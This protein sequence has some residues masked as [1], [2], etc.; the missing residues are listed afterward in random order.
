M[1]YDLLFE[2]LKTGFCLILPYI[3]C[4][5]CV[6]LSNCIIFSYDDKIKR[7]ELI[8]E[9]KD[10]LLRF[11]KGKIIKRKLFKLNF[12]KFL[13]DVVNYISDVI[14][15]K[16][17]FFGDIIAFILFMSVVIGT[18][19]C[20]GAP[21][22]FFCEKNELGQFNEYKTFIEQKEEIN[23]KERIESEM[24][25]KRMLESFFVDKDKVELIDLYEVEKKYLK[26][27]EKNEA[28]GDN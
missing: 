15:L 3:F 8:E 22:S 18:L 6:V 17:K 12:K 9:L 2:L 27:I 10:P 7:K 24:Y 14:F 19:V 13:D 28:S 1:R 11:S 25:N 4:L 20:I 21:F 5:L 23:L 26:G 16:K